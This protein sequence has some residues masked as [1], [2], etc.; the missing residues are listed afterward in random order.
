[1]VTMSP[2]LVY[3]LFL[4][5]ADPEVAP[6][7]MA[8]RHPIVRGA[9]GGEHALVYG[10]IDPRVL[11]PGGDLGHP[12]GTR[13]KLTRSGPR[14]GCTAVLRAA[15]SGGQPELID[16]SGY[17]GQWWPTRPGPTPLR[18][19]LA[20]GVL[21]DAAC[22]M[23]ENTFHNGSMPRANARLEGP[24]GS[25]CAVPLTAPVLAAGRVDPKGE[26]RDRMN[27]RMAVLNEVKARHWLVKL[28]PVDE[29][30]G[31]G[32]RPGP[33]SPRRPEPELWRTHY[34]FHPIGPPDRFELYVSSP[35]GLTRYHSGRRLD[36]GW[37]V[38]RWD[39]VSVHPPA[40]VG[41]FYVAADGADRHFVV[42]GGRVFTLPADAQP[43]SA[44]VKT[45]DTDPVVA[46]VHDAD[47]GKSF[48][49]TPTHSFHLTSKPD[50]KP[51]GLTAFPGATG[52]EAL[53][54]VARCGR[55]IRGVK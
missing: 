49:F 31:P 14:S 48:A 51:H 34:D 4:V 53:D 25:I 27:A 44:L 24:N 40:W 33:P 22:G 18:W 43:G 9:L 42:P 28:W 26:G 2:A 20:G 7:V 32:N 21:Y 54:T 10:L 39:E 52:E 29:R 15:L 3:A 47:S 41:P 19:H 17:G 23:D 46:L 30:F 11:L 8:N 16:L 35:L 38:N 37:E 6:E 12:A 1:M 45:W 36:N 13:L 5:A 50:P 55:V